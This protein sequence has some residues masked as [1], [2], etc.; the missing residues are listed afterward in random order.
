M[1]AWEVVVLLQHEPT[2]LSLCTHR[3]ISLR[4]IAA[5]P[6]SSTAGSD[7]PHHA[8]YMDGHHT[9][10]STPIHTT[11]LETHT[12][13]RLAPVPESTFPPLATSHAIS[14]DSSYTSSQHASGPFAAAAAAAVEKTY[15]TSPPHHHDL[16]PLSS[17]YNNRGS[18]GSPGG[19][20]AALVGRVEREH[21]DA[22]SSVGSGADGGR[23]MSL[24]GAGMTQGMTSAASRRSSGSRHMSRKQSRLSGI[25]SSGVGSSG[26]SWTSSDTSSFTVGLDRLAEKLRARPSTGSGSGYVAPVEEEQHV[27][28]TRQRIKRKLRRTN[29]LPSPATTA[30][31][32]LAISASSSGESSGGGSDEEN[33]GGAMQQ[34]QHAR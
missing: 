15:S 9:D 29:S 1:A 28:K 14:T 22:V 2:C 31:P 12:S 32:E 18:M 4:S 26:P 5:A 3:S 16:P 24:A 7:G 21:S 11:P 20:F 17:S 6:T 8:Y 23:R 34:Q 13:V 33:W 19:S 27:V 30:I 10:G 25:E